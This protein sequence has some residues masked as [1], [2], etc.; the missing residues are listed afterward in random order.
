MNYINLLFLASLSIVITSCSSTLK[1]NDPKAKIIYRVTRNLSRHDYMAAKEQIKELGSPEEILSYN[2]TDSLAVG[3]KRVAEFTPAIMNIFI[4]SLLDAQKIIDFNCSPYS[5]NITSLAKDGTIESKSTN[6]LLLTSKC[7]GNDADFSSL[8]NQANQVFSD[9]TTSEVFGKIYSLQCGDVDRRSKNKTDSPKAIFECYLKDQEAEFKKKYETASKEDSQKAKEKHE[10]EFQNPE[11]P[12]VNIKNSPVQTGIQHIE[13]PIYENASFRNAC[14][15]REELYVA[16]SRFDF[17]KQM[18]KQFGVFHKDEL[19]QWAQ[20]KNSSTTNL[21]DAVTKY[22]KEYHKKF[23]QISCPAY[24]HDDDSQIAKGFND[25]PEEKVSD[26]LCELHRQEKFFFKDI[27]AQ[28]KMAKQVEF[29]DTNA[30][31]D[32]GSG[33]LVTQKTLKIVKG[34]YSKRF[35]KTFNLKSC[36]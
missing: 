32:S 12:H 18:Q 15:A 1:D 9:L 17:Q 24:T 31:Y 6:A 20:I 16:N 8:R 4:G 13:D 23:N 7:Y 14:E 5:T 22:E 26:K 29:Y 21:K 34:I 27:A 36:K 25:I 19:L 28:A 10:A 3:T 35:K 33:L 11:E 2:V 30:L